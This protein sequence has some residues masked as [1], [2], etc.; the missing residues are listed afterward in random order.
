MFDSPDSPGDQAEPRAEVG[1]QRVTTGRKALHKVRRVARRVVRLA[2]PRRV[3]ATWTRWRI[4]RAQPRRVVL[5]ASGIAPQGWVPTEEDA[6]NLLHR[7]D[8]RIFEDYPADAFLA[9]HVWEHLTLEE[10]EVAARH[11]HGALRTGG[12]VR[13]AVPDGGKPDQDWR[14]AVK[15]GGHGAGADD[16]RVLYTVETLTEIF[17]R[18]G[19]VVEPLEYHDGSGR[20]H[21][22]PWDPADGMIHRSLRFDPRNRPGDVAA[23]SI[24]LDAHKRGT[25]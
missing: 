20:F 25:P 9:E 19:F 24:I 4:R 13:V 17:E 23:P 7:S 5:G 1:I 18:V 22:H 6:L 15:P 3:R 12:Y 14:A 11:C 10:G 8:W 21:A 16:H 2:T